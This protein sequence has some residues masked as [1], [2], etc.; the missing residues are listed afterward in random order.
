M[1][2][3]QGLVEHFQFRS[4]CLSTH[5]NQRQTRSKTLKAQLHAKIHRSINELLHN[6]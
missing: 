1:N 4:N 2:E 3:T 5:L 6:L